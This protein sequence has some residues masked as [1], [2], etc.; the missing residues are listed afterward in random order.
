MKTILEQMPRDLVWVDPNSAVYKYISG[1]L[2]EPDGLLEAKKAG[3][4]PIVKFIYLTGIEA[5]PEPAPSFPDIWRAF[6]GNFNQLPMPNI[7]ASVGEIRYTK[8]VQD[9]D[10]VMAYRL[11][12]FHQAVGDFVFMRSAWDPDL[13]IDELMDEAAGFFV[14]DSRNRAKMKEALLALEQFWQDVRSDTVH[15]SKELLDEIRE[16]ET[17]PGWWFD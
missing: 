8:A 12:P 14:S 13:T 5:A 16:S 10:G 1:T 15:K 6:H 17:T 9:P 3:F 7:A 2:D 4:D 11:A